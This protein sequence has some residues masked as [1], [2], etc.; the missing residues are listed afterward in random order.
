MV[1]LAIFVVI[2]TID[3]DCAKRPKVC[4]A[5]LAVTGGNAHQP[6]DA[7]SLAKPSSRFCAYVMH[8]TS[9]VY[10]CMSALVYVRGT[11]GL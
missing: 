11:P 8:T 6:H 4:W 9:L 2:L 5:S 1:I 7:E 10:Q 3:E